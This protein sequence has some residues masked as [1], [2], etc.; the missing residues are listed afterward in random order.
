MAKI[1]KVGSQNITP[2]KIANPFRTS[3]NS[4][5]NPFK[6]NN[7]EG[8]TLPLELAADV[9]AGTKTEKPNRLKMIATSV[10]GSMNKMKSSFTE[11]IVN[12]ANRMKERVGWERFHE[13]Y[14]YQTVSENHQEGREE[15]IYMKRGNVLVNIQ[16]R[17]NQIESYGLML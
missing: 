11:S 6:Y 17:R 1:I 5:T 12:F 2:N 15:E 7:F 8:T 14:D 10:T 13:G 16:E 3:R 9:F 4:T